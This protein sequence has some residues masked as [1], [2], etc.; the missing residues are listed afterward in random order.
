MK[1]I[2]H[3]PFHFFTFRH[4]SMVSKPF[5]LGGKHLSI[6]SIYS[7]LLLL[8]SNTSSFHFMQP[9]SSPFHHLLHPTM[10][11]LLTAAMQKQVVGR[12]DV[13][14]F[15]HKNQQ[16]KKK[17]LHMPKPKKLLHKRT[18]SP[19]IPFNRNQGP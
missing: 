6:L 3:Y 5:S 10:G 8:D 7:H 17:L 1:T 18:M 4:F 15:L 14:L 19:T 11:R 16:P 9:K 2:K 13:L 12:K